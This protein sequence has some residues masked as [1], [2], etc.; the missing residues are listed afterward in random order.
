MYNK[1]IRVNA[2]TNEKET[3]K[4]L[5][6]AKAITSEQ[7]KLV[8]EV[9]AHYDAMTVESVIYNSKCQEHEK[10]VKVTQEMIERYATRLYTRQELRTAHFVL[11][12]KRAAMYFV[13]KNVACKRKSDHLYDLK[14]LR[15]KVEKV[16]K[17]ETK[18]EVEKALEASTKRANKRKSVKLIETSNAV[19]TSNVALAS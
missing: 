2:E 5:I 17:S 8:N 18:N 9:I 12:N 3:C 7:M 4:V 10:D 1:A 6:N 14:V 13:S 19:E 16:A 11:R 15:A